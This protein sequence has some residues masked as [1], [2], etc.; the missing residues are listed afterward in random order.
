MQLRK[1]SDILNDKSLIKRASR[2]DREAFA[3]VFSEIEQEL[4]R[5]AYIYVRNRDDALD[6]VQ[7]T[8]L[9]CFE[10]AQ[11]LRKKDYF[12]TWAVRIAINCAI[13]FLRK[14]GREVSFEGGE[15]IAQTTES[16]ESE[17]VSRIT[18]QSLLNLLDA[19]EKTVIILKYHYGYTFAEI[20]RALKIP[21]GTAKSIHYRA[22]K[23]LRTEGGNYE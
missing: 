5:V 15:Y 23:K 13:D 2:G 18:L 4:Y 14:N 19:P 11:M 16:A 20:S 7:E 17:A 9:R 22:I 10:S 1:G 3:K 8:A 6:V 21:L 12:R